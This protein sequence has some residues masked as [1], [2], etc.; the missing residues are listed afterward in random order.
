MISIAK[1]KST[2]K[3][4]HRA[5]PQPHTPKT[6]F[7]AINTGKEKQGLVLALCVSKV[8]IIQRDTQRPSGNVKKDR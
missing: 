1:T 7:F 8:L 5:I 2:K 4:A 6:H 3:I